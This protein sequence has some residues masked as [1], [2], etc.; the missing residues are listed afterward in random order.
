MEEVILSYRANTKK[1]K[2][3]KAEIGGQRLGGH[4]DQKGQILRGQR[5]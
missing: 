5:D 2:D 4:K 1:P 3:E